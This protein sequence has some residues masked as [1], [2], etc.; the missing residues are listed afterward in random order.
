MES[1]FSLRFESGDRAGEVVPIEGQGFTIGRRP[2]QSLQILDNSVSGKHAEIVADANGALLRDLGSTN[3]T[4]VG[5]E[6]VTE[7]RLV[8]G[9]RVHFGNVELVFLDAVAGGFRPGVAAAPGG[10]ATAG[11]TSPTGPLAA[12]SGEAVLRVSPEI[13]ARSRKRSV[14]GLLLLLVLVGGAAGAWLYFG[15]T[16]KASGAGPRPATPAADNLLGSDYSFE[17][18]T[19]GWEAAEGAPAA[20]LR[21][22]EGRVSGGLGLQVE[23][24]G[25]EFALHRS[26][27]I[28]AEPGRMLT[29]KAKLEVEGESSA[30]VGIDLGG[31]IAW[32]TP[33]AGTR[34]G[35][36]GFETVEVSTLVPP[37]RE[38]VRLVI[39][40]SAGG[41]GTV[42]AD[43]AELVAGEA[44]VESGR[45]PRK[46]VVRD[47]ELVL[48]GDPARGAVL[49]RFGK[50]LL[51]LIAF[52][53]GSSAPETAAASPMTVR[54]E[55]TR[56]VLASTAGGAAAC[57]RAEP[58]L[59]R[60]GLATIGGDGY[61]THG[62]DFER[63]GVTSLLFGKGAELV[64][65]VFAAPVAVQGVA[66]GSSSR[67]TA[68]GEIAEIV[69]QLDFTEDRKKAGD[70]AHAARNAEKKGDLG[71]C[72]ARWAELLNAFP[73][74]A[75]LVGEAEAKRA[76]L[77]QQGLSELQAVRSE[78]ERAE[79]FRLVDLYRQC[80][81][82]AVGVGTRFAG[83]EVELEASKVVEEA[84]R[85]LAGFE[86]E[87]AR[88]EQQ[89]LRAILA[90]LEARKAAGL[91]AK[92]RE[93]A[94]ALGAAAPR[95]ED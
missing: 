84:N 17:S 42:A 66:E 82:R 70:L 71:E 69:L 73:F 52:G 36:S 29:G 93:H 9:A 63:S 47:Y 54:S 12:E 24:A 77:V 76:A 39:L 46:I 92:V 95:K 88:V 74:D 50:T 61:S 65:I 35:D 22:A 89:R 45:E 32:S 94:D 51:S 37:G 31:V 20:F 58:A 60:A 2:G 56:L 25:G 87:L 79:F 19:D 38:T 91:A 26:R 83:S 40:A 90:G 85:H 48:L 59:V 41:S 5:G 57:I 44:G 55:E 11:A 53:A 15:G 68:R 34:P 14:A 16:S 81:S 86:A 6:R 33:L 62:L 78:I 80:R 18:E 67:V 30:Q 3:G 7:T 21:G 10:S 72:L 23:L 1:R 4:R 27:E 28:R 13:L 64:R 43:D 75:E 8:N 49:A